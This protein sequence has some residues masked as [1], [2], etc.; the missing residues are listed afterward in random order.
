MNHIFAVYI[1]N[2][3]FNFIC[4]LF[5]LFK[6]KFI[7]KNTKKISTVLV[8]LTTDDKF[9]KLYIITQKRFSI[10]IKNTYKGLKKHWSLFKLL[11]AFSY[12]NIF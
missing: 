4:F 1:F 9:Q 12:K 7:F 10:V 6:A 5:Y 3:F 2:Y 8:V 11:N